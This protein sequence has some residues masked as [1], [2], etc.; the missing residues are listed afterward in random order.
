MRSS[1]AITAEDPET[2]TPTP[3]RVTDVPCAGRARGA[4]RFG[5][6]CRLRD[7]AVLR[8]HGRAS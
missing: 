4:R 8:Q 2:F 1:A 5:A 7:P 6:L 3:G